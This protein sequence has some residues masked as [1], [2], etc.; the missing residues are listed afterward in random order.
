MR[1]HDSDAR[2]A[3]PNRRMWGEVQ[4]RPL[5]ADFDPAGRWR[6]HPKSSVLLQDGGECSDPLIGFKGCGGGKGK[7]KGKEWVGQGL[8]AQSLRISSRPLVLRVTFG[9]AKTQPP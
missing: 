8:H 3:E 1:P 2:S 7:E 9:H 5:N 6:P 4:S